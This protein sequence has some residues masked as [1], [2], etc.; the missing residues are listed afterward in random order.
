MNQ[1]HSTSQRILGLLKR[2]HQLSINDL[3]Q[4]LQITDMAVRKHMIRL[5]KEQLIQS[6]QVKQS[7]GR[8]ITYYS[9]SQTGE[10]LFPK[11]YSSLTL[12]FLQDIEDLYG[13]EAVNKLFTNRENRLYQKYRTVISPSKKLKEKV[14]ALEKL[15]NEHGYM[16]EVQTSGPEEF[17]LTEYNCPIYQVAQQY[18][19]ACHCE[20]SLFKRVL[21]VQQIERTSC[22]S[23]G[24]HCCRY[25]IK[26][27]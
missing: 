21:G 8:P 12:E 3:K 16:A 25:M 18:K 6:Q 11:K 10:N 5:E 19:K 17:E 27:N 22:I 23:E 20:L 13:I 24:D 7:I 14:K 26:A 2:Y 9:L 15:Q 1:L 4:H